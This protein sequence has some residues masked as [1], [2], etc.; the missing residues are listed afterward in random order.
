MQEYLIIK[1]NRN[2][3]DNNH[4]KKISIS[5]EIKQKHTQLKFVY[6]A[7]MRNRVFWQINFADTR[8]MTYEKQL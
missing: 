8:K 5:M 6:L 3:K 1:H 2:Q 7:H 4:L